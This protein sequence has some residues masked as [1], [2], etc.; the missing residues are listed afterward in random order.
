[1]SRLMGH[2]S[3]VTP[4][5][6]I[7]LI[8]HPNHRLLVTRS[9][10]RASKGWFHKKW[11]NFDDN[12]LKPCLLKKRAIKQQKQQKEEIREFLQAPD[13][14]KGHELEHRG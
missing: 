2:D 8:T 9:D 7:S 14:Y 3:T 1:M 12:V 6:E 10:V 11:S 13:P 5:S 4:D